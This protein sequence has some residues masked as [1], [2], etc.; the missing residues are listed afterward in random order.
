MSLPHQTTVLI[1][2]AG[3]AGMAAAISLSKQG[4]QDITIVDAVLTGENSSRAL[5]IQAATMEALNTVG[6]L[7]NLLNMGVKMD[8]V[9]ILSG[10]S[11]LLSIDLSGLS[12]YT[13]FPFGLI[14]PQYLTESGMLERLHEAG[15][16]V[17]RPFKV[18]ALKQSQDHM[19]DAHFES[20]DVVRAMYVIGADGAHS[21]VRHE[22]GITFK[23][24]DGDEENDYGN[25]SQ[26]V[27][28]DVTFSS[29]PQLPSEA[30]KA[31]ISIDNGNFTLLSPP[32]P[33]QA[34]PDPD[35]LVYRYVSTVPVERQRATP[36]APSTE[37]LQ[38]LLDRGP[39]TL[40]SD[41]A[42]NPHPMHIEHTLWSSRYRTHAAIA[43]RCFARLPGG[44]AVFLVG[45][46]AHIHSPVGG[47]GMSLGIR[48]AISL[49]P[50]L[51]AHSEGAASDTL[52]EDW[53]AN[54][55]A[56]A[57][58]VISLTKQALGMIARPAARGM[59]APLWWLGFVALR[60]MS[61]FAFVQRLIAY[62]LSGLAE[63]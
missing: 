24:P 53:A 63:I 37:Y 46:A 25:F 9:N 60:V 27:L 47:Q 2:G 23:D 19:V 51:R 28:G 4:I 58:A 57:L 14:L 13:K 10:S 5:V 52:L 59:W 54:R 3:P 22:A 20:G 1:V 8:R 33:A 30:S 21:T 35:H 15:I 34:S 36:H 7:D 56:R 45:D 49:G 62:R 41:P 43:D 40:S 29:P 42:V 32:F 48:D 26:M 11:T 31:F 50:V 38:A 12:R 16:K 17:L 6:C 39:V 18:I 61:K 44:G 55:H